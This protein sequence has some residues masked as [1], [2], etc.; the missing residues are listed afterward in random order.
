MADFEPIA[1]NTTAEK[2]EKI[3]NMDIN[4]TGLDESSDNNSLPTSKLVYDT[5][6]NLGGGGGGNINVDQTYKP[7][8]ENAQS[9]KAVAEAVKSI[10]HEKTTLIGGTIEDW[11]VA[12][13]MPKSGHKYDLVIEPFTIRTWLNG[14]YTIYKITEHYKD[15][16][17]NVIVD[18]PKHYFNDVITHRQRVSVDNSLGNIA[19]VEVRLRPETNT[20]AYVLFGD[21]ENLL[22]TDRKR[23][24]DTETNVNAVSHYFVYDKLTA[25]FTTK[26]LNSTYVGGGLTKL[27]KPI[28]KGDKVTF[29]IDAPSGDENQHYFNWYN[30]GTRITGIAN[31]NGF[32]S[33]LFEYTHNHEQDITALEFVLVKVI[34]QNLYT[35]TIFDENSILEK[36]D[37]LSKSVD[38]ISS[39]AV[40]VPD[41]YKDHLSGAI[42]RAKTNLLNAGVEGETFVFISDLHWESNAKNSPALIGA[43]TNE[44]PIENV[45]FGGDAF[46]GGAYEDKVADMND[47]RKQ[48]EKV[49]KRFLSIYGNHD[50]NWLDGGT[51]FSNRE[52]YTL[53]QKQNDYLCNFDNPS[54]NYCFYFD[55]PTTKTRMILLDTGMT[56]PYHPD[57]ELAWLQST[58]SN[59]PSGYN[60]LVFAHII[61]VP[62]SGGSYND[63]TTWEMTTFMTSVCE[64]LDGVTDKNVKAIFGGHSHYDYVSKTTGGIPI[65]LI[66]CDTRQTSSGNSQAL[67]SVNEQAFDIVTVNYKTNTVHCVRVGRGTDRTIEK[68]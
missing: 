35:I 44:L 14:G 13:F 55:N 4:D 36:V 48:F 64:Y 67:G 59:A 53:L 60:I 10:T 29:R 38:D 66:D 54:N 8:S 28:R 11:S 68:Q 41:Y 32:G 24:D 50:S 62:Q 27:N 23:L 43:I 5:I 37:D 2:L 7:E 42:S 40:Q 3:A 9:G 18:A 61:F 20:E 63:P 15:G 21:L 51:G 39:G 47:I 6:K 49:S 45:I 58:V 33:R 57:E 52:F 17:S 16:T 56:N 25:D 26:A 30:G 12:E 1:V 22:V 34:Q 46:N 65:I 19:K 31:Q